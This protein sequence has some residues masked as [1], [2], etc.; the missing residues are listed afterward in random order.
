MSC[1]CKYAGNNGLFYPFISPRLVIIF[2][3]VQEQQHARLALA[4]I[5][6]VAG[7][8]LGKRVLQTLLD[9]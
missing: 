3:V 2:V 8:R 9:T 5:A 6:G 1:A 7:P 4:A